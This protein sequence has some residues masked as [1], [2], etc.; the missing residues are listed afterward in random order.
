MPQVSSMTRDVRITQEPTLP[1]ELGG[2]PRECPQAFE[3]NASPLSI[4]GMSGRVGRVILPALTSADPDDVCAQI[5]LI[6]VPWL[7]IGFESSAAQ[8]GG[9]SRVLAE[10]PTTLSGQCLGVCWRIAWDECEPSRTWSPSGA[11]GAPP[12]GSGSPRAVVTRRASSQ[13]S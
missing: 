7:K 4:I 8:N 13:R 1:A 5:D 9:S 2:R 10:A 11:A 6:S 12:R 3:K